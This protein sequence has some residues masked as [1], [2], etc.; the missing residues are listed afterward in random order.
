MT[1]FPLSVRDLELYIGDAGP[2]TLSIVGNE[3]QPLALDGAD[4]ATFEV[5][6][7]IAADPPLLRRST[8]EATLSIVASSGKLVAT[9]TPEESTG[10]PPGLWLGQAAV[11]FGSEDAWRFSAPFYVRF[12]TTAVVP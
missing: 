11:R 12:R 5:R 9:L 7:A 8:A 6:R 10:L 2:I 4:G 3:G 1:S